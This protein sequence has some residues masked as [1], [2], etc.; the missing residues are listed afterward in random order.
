MHVYAE[1]NGGIGLLACVYTETNG[2]IE[3]T[4]HSRLSLLLI[5]M[6]CNLIGEQF[7]CILYNIILQ[8]KIHFSN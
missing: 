1:R 3:E 8:R 6:D 7:P 5:D 2:G 4:L